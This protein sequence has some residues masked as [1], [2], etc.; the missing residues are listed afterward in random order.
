MTHKTNYSFATLKDLIDVELHR[1]QPREVASLSKITKIW[2]QL[3]G[4]VIAQNTRLVSL[5][6]HILWVSVANNTWACE[7]NLLKDELLE[8]VNS[9]QKNSIEDIKFFLEKK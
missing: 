3:V 4:N 9:T 7:L 6:N 5:K 1:L 2:P 8:K